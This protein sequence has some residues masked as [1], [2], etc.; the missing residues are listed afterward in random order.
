MSNNFHR[1]HIKENDMIKKNINKK[2]LKPSSVKIVK[3]NN[4]NFA[5]AILLDNDITKKNKENAHKRI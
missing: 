1:N 5:V 4:K 3:L 2:K